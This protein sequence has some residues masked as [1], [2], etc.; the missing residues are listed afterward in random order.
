MLGNVQNCNLLI[1]IKDVTAQQPLST[2]SRTSQ[3]DRWLTSKQHHLTNDTILKP[4]WSQTVAMRVYYCAWLY[5]QMLPSGKGFV[6]LLGVA[7]A[8]LEDLWRPQQWFPPLPGGWSPS[9]SCC[10][11][12]W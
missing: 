6:P 2:L 11:C 3:V 1:V 10:S 8:S 7:G 4:N 12:Q 5:Q 9:G